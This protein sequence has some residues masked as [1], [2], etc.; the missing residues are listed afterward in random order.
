MTAQ[1]ITY[2]EVL[3]A[4]C[5]VSIMLMAF[6][7][8]RSLQGML[9]TRM[10]LVRQIVGLRRSMDPVM[11]ELRSGAARFRA[12]GQSVLNGAEQVSELAERLSSL[13]GRMQ[14]G[15]QAVWALSVQ[16]AGALFKTR[17]RSTP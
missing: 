5:T 12:A 14:K 1:D 8:M 16:S 6:F 9:E 13:G 17:K 10:K 11:A 3:A 15:V 7:T 4:L 2:F